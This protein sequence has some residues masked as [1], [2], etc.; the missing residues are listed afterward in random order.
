MKPL[1]QEWVQKAEGDW[2]TAQRE[3]AAEP[4]NYDAVCFHSQQCAE[5]Y[6]KALLQ[7]R[8]TA[9]PKTHDLEQ[10]IDLLLPDLPELQTW[11]AFAKALTESAIAVRYPG[12]SVGVEEAREAL[13]QCRTICNE[14]RCTLGLSANSS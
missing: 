3:F 14:M 5:K 4:A 7:A 1:T 11:R 2:L 13:E 6:L 10:L 12:E 8:G 9:F